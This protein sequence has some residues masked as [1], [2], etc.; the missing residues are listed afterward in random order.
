MTRAIFI[1]LGLLLLALL[2]LYPLAR[3]QR[4]GASSPDRNDL[5]RYGQVL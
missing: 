5:R 4:A 3:A 1:A 2:L